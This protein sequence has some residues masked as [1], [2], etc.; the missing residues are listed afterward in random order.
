TARRARPTSDPDGREAHMYLKPPGAAAPR[1]TAGPR[2]SGSR[3]VSGRASVVMPVTGSDG[4][5]EIC[6]RSGLGGL[7][8]LL[9][10]GAADRLDL[11]AGGLA[12]GD[13]HR[14]RGL[15]LASAEQLDLGDPLRDQAPG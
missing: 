12:D 4:G 6:A 14:E 2:A 8:G 11:L 13:G 15:E 1:T 3:P 9:L 10:D 5:P 7:G